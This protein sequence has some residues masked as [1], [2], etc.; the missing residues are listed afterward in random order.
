MLK[1]LLKKRENEN[2]TRVLVERKKMEEKNVKDA[3]KPG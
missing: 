2:L 1:K 3:E